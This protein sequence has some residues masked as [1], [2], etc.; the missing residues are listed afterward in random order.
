[1]IHLHS[2]EQYNHHALTY[3][4]VQPCTTEAI[5]AALHNLPMVTHDFV[6]SNKSAALTCGH[7]QPCTA[8][9]IRA[10][11]HNL[12]MVTHDFLKSNKFAALTCGH[13]QPC[14]AEA[15]CTALHNLPIVLHQEEVAASCPYII[16][17]L[18]TRLQ[19][20]R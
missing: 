11:L 17:Q 16:Q 3:R 14:T 1:M 20:Q 6:K 18:L 4:H 7:V 10:A 8:E 2:L 13:V 9:A 15:I 19:Q 5:R 12:P